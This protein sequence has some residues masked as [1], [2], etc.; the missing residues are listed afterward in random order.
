MHRS[1][2]AGQN[3]EVA[4]ST[5]FPSSDSICAGQ[6][7]SVTLCVTVCVTMGVTPPVTVAVTPPVTLVVTPRATSGICQRGAVNVQV[8]LVIYERVRG[9][10]MGVAGR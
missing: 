7:D 10:H 9:A 3:V 4:T 6:S 2:F 1:V 5:H 8:E